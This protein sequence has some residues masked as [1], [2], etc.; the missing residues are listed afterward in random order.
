MWPSNGLAIEYHR[1]KLFK[2]IFNLYCSI[3]ITFL[4]GSNLD[5]K[6]KFWFLFL[7]F[8]C[9]QW[10]GAVQMWE[11]RQ[12]HPLEE[13]RKMDREWWWERRGMRKRSCMKRAREREREVQTEVNNKPRRT[14][15][16]SDVLSR[17]LDRNDF[18]VFIWRAL[19]PGIK[20]SA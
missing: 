15:R 10:D 8:V 9:Q 3:L 13:E 1:F 14:E 17:M 12:T 5:K 4:L 2:F 7:L 19:K 20:N 16:D 18:Y 6:Y 11:H